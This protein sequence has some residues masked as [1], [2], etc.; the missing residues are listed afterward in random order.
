MSESLDEYEYPPDLAAEHTAALVF[1]S[2]E[3]EPPRRRPLRGPHDHRP[4]ASDIRRFK[5]VALAK[6]ARRAMRAHVR[7]RRSAR[8]QAVSQRRRASP[9][10]ARGEPDPAPPADGPSICRG[11]PSRGGNS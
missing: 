7:A 9:A 2:S 11:E 1:G 6:R 5:R 8:R 10:T 3:D 4:R